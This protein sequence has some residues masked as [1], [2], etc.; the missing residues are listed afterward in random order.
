M[1]EETNASPSDIPCKN[2]AIN[3]EEY[4]LS[5]CFNLIFNTIESRKR[6]CKSSP[7]VC[8][9]TADQP[10]APGISDHRFGLRQSAL[11]RALRF[12][13]F[14][15]YG[16]R[17]SRMRNGCRGNQHSSTAIR[18]GTEAIVQTDQA[19][20]VWRDFVPADLHSASAKHSDCKLISGGNCDQNILYR[21][22]YPSGS[23]RYIE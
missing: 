7:P 12:Y 11:R 13:F 6:S 10:A 5:H 20:R 18:I 16:Q 4:E 15:P 9:P 2:L 3:T 21:P 17:R 19:C 14:R 1:P 23:A 8:H 22:F